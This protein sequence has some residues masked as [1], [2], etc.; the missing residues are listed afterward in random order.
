MHT[1]TGF[2]SK[3]KSVLKRFVC[4]QTNEPIGWRA[5]FMPTDHYLCNYEFDCVIAAD[6]KRNSLPGFPRREMRGKLAIGIT[7][8][9][10]NNRT[11]AEERV[12]EISGVTCIYKQV[13]ETTNRSQNVCSFQGVLQEHARGDWLR[14]GEH[15][16][17]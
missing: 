11:H 6:G 13:N 17:L 10:V 12:N 8:N 2:I 1:S 4:A 9:F 14:F 7:A 16:L 3:N 15:C 5:E